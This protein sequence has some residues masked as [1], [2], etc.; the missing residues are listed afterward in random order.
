[1]NTKSIS[2]SKKQNVVVQDLKTKKNPTGG[3]SALPEAINPMKG[4]VKVRLKQLASV[5]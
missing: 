3:S 5:L 4:K 1:M 2:S